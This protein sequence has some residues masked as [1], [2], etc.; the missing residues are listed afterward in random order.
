MLNQ[1]LFPILMNMYVLCSYVSLQ[2]NDA[3]SEKNVYYRSM[4]PLAQTVET[5]CKIESCYQVEVVEVWV[6]CHPSNTLIIKTK[7]IW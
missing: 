3:S 4:S 5:N 6:L 2:M 7:S 1:I